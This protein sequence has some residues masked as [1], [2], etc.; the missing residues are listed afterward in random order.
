M[1]LKTSSKIF[2][3]ADVMHWAWKVLLIIYGFAFIFVEFTIGWIT[4]FGA[5]GLLIFL[6]APL[7]LPFFIITSWQFAIPYFA[8]TLGLLYYW[9]KRKQ[10]IKEGS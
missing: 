1:L 7:W 4:P 5:T 2:I 8:V 6:T 10:K 3:G 9:E